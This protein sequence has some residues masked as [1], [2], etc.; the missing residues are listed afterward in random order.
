[1]MR[2]P[3]VNSIS[4]RRSVECSVTLRDES[5]AD[6]TGPSSA[7][8]AL[9]KPGSDLTDPLRK[10]SAKSPAANA[11]G[12]IAALSPQPGVAQTGFPKQSAPSPPQTNAAADPS[13][14]LQ[15]DSAH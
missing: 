5:A 13:P 10:P 11:T 15:V 7:T 3:L 4:I 8:I 6:G 1:M 14:P 9:T 12:H 2:R